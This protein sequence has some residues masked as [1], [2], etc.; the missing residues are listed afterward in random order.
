MRQWFRGVVFPSREARRPCRAGDAMVVTEERRVRSGGAGP[1][2]AGQGNGNGNVDGHR[3]GHPHGHPGGRRRAAWA[4]T[5]A[6]VTGARR[7]VQRVSAGH[8]FYFP[9]RCVRAPEGFSSIPCGAAWLRVRCKCPFPCPGHWK[10][11]PSAGRAELAGGSAVPGR[12]WQGMLQDAGIREHGRVGE[13]G[14]QA[15]L[16]GSFAVTQLP[17]SKD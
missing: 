13:F 1:G 17:Y 12:A 16:H 14:A 3:D 4:V 8:V 7:R 15:F 11:H 5:A 2:R 6:P 9:L 10:T